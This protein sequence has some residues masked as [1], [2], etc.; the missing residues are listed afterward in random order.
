MKINEILEKSMHTPI[1]LYDGECGFCDRTIRFFLEKDSLDKLSFTSLQGPTGQAIL[2][3]YGVATLNFE[4]IILLSQKKIYKKSS[5]VLL[6]L[7]KLPFPWKLLYA[8]MIIPRFIRNYV[9][10]LVSKNRHR[11]FNKKNN[12][13]LPTKKM[14]K[15]M[16]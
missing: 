16:I 9:Y 2:V 8:F 6:A 5:A 12:C 4:T 11:L 10:S 14:R 13:D 3:H 7:K 1:I 15:K